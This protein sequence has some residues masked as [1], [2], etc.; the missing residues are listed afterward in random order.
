MRSIFISWL[1]VISPLLGAAQEAGPRVVN[2]LGLVQKFENVSMEASIGEIAITTLTSLD[3]TITQGFLQPMEESPCASVDIIYYPNPTQDL[4]TIEAI[5][6]DNQIVS[7]E[8]ID[9]WGRLLETFTPDEE[10]KVSMATFSQGLYLL[11]VTL[12]TGIVKAV[13]AIK[14]SA[15]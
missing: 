8:V 11:K 1:A 15:Q 10:S 3:N 7:V 12:K 4:V 2:S 6:C 5:G 13:S 14:V 9:V